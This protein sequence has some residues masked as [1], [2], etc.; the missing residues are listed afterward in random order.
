MED[1][2][3]YLRSLGLSTVVLHNEKSE[4]WLKQVEKGAFIYLFI[5]PDECGKMVKAPLQ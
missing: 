1:Q 4:E 2:V 5:S 3:A